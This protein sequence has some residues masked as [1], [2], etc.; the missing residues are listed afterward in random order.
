[1]PAITQD[2]NDDDTL[3]PEVAYLDKQ[4]EE[5][6]AELLPRRLQRLMQTTNFMSSPPAGILQAALNAFIGNAYMQELHQSMA[7]NATPSGLE[8]VANGVVHPVTKETITK[9]KKLINDPLLWD[10]WMKGICKTLGRLTQGCGKKGADDYVKG[11]KHSPIH[12]FGQ[13]KDDSKRPSGNVC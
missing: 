3:E 7:A 1:M 10:D 12:G 2:Y 8:E 9:Y 13:N 4:W 6:A 11:K 5:E